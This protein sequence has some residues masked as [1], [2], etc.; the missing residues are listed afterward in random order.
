MYSTVLFNFFTC[1]SGRCWSTY[2]EKNRKYYSPPS[3]AKTI[4]L[5]I[6]VVDVEPKKD[7]N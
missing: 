1:C 2:L 4:H 7:H 5:F 3:L 6:L